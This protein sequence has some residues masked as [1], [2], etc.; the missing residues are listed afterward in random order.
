MFSTNE[1]Q[2]DNVNMAIELQLRVFNGRPNVTGQDM[3]HNLQNTRLQ[4]LRGTL[5][6]SV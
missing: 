1:R 6:L 3:G 5:T 2:L 4:I